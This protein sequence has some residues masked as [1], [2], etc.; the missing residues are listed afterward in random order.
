MERSQ[1][2]RWVRACCSTGRW[3]VRRYAPSLP[4]ASYRHAT[5]AAPR[6]TEDFWVLVNLSVDSEQIVLLGA[7][8][9]LLY[10]VVPYKLRYLSW[11]FSP[12]VLVY[13]SVL[14]NGQSQRV[15]TAS[16]SAF[17][18]VL[19]LFHRKKTRQIVSSEKFLKKSYK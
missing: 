17:L 3:G 15:S 2:Q 19:L 1:R 5:T 13:Y 18:S 16:P 11:P 14:I 7:L 10:V 9:R 4:P 12:T 6:T 8:C